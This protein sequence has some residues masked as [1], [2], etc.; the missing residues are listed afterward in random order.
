MTTLRPIVARPDGLRTPRIRALRDA[1]FGYGILPWARGPLFELLEI[2]DFTVQTAMGLRRFRIP[3]G[4]R[5]NKASTPPLLW[6]PPFRLVPDGLCTVPSLEHDF[7]CDILLGGSEWLRLRLPAEMLE[8]LPVAQVHDY[9]ERRLM[10]FGMRPFRARAW[11]LA[12]KCVGP[13]TLIGKIVARIF[14]S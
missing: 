9:F 1:D 6:G 2:H 13:G 7:L 11:G 10:A 14:G 12:V 4:Y 5:F 8:P 3:Q